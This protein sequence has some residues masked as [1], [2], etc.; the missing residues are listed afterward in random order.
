MQERLPSGTNTNQELGYLDFTWDGHDGAS[1]YYRELDIDRAVASVRYRVE[2]SVISR[3]LLASA[4]HQALVYRIE[5]TVHS[6]L[7]G[8]IVFD[9]A[10]VPEVME[11]EGNTMRI[12][13]LAGK[14]HGVSF[15]ARIH[16]VTEGGTS[17]VTERGWKINDCNA[18]TIIPSLINYIRI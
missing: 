18:V 8:T 6:M 15:H 4:P 10:A 7:T 16:L 14:K 5:S 12:R 2:R 1:D 13:G 17:K 9:R 3:T 11:V